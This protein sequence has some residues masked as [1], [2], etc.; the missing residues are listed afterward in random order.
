MN[1]R[2]IVSLGLVAA[3]VATVVSVAASTGAA[4]PRKQLSIAFIPPV[5]ANPIIKALNDGIKIKAES[6]GMQ[7]STVGGEYNPQAQIVAMNAAIQKRF[8][9]IA[10][11]PLDPKSIQ[12]SL[13]KARKAYIPLVVIETPGVKPYLTNINEN[14]VES[15][16]AVAEYGAKAAKKKFGSCAVGIIEGIPVVDV[17]RNRNIGLE[18]GAKAQ[19]CT[20]LDKQINTKDITDG[21]RPIV[22]AWKTKYGSKMNLI[23]AYNDPSAMAAVSAVDSNW[24]P[25]ITGSNADDIAVQAIRQ[26][27]LLATSA[28]PNVEIG[29]AIAWALYLALVKHQRVPQELNTSNYII[30]RQNIKTYVP[31]SQKLKRPLNVSFVNRGGQ[32]WINAK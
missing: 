19:G 9:A 13:D 31:P 17:L 22:D 12:P 14:D 21:A 15:S 24:K 1:R 20:V 26:G 10:I 30:N 32:W 6:L 2:K 16:A 28:T 27:T 25:L 5:I 18:Q 29:N 8:D 23:L 11:W 4:K 7:F 3:V